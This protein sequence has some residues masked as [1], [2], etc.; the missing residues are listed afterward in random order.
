MPHIISEIMFNVSGWNLKKSLE[1]RRVHR[2]FLVSVCCIGAVS[3]GRFLH[4]GCYAT[5]GRTRP[6]GRLDTRGT[7]FYSTW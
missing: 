3:W 2:R 7:C 6:D 5:K 1:I 4:E